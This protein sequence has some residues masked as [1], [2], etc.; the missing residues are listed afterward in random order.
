MNQNVSDTDRQNITEC[1]QCHNCFTVSNYIRHARQCR[2]TKRLRENPDVDDDTM[3]DRVEENVTLEN[4][5]VDNDTSTGAVEE[6]VTVPDDESDLFSPD[7]DE[8]L[9]TGLFGDPYLDSLMMNGLESLEPTTE[10]DFGAFGDATDNES[11]TC[12]RCPYSDS[13]SRNR[14]Q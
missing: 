5:Y 10:P 12:Q 6:N 7:L 1:S 8:G 11:L 9:K 13:T 2:F 4:P 3:S 14:R